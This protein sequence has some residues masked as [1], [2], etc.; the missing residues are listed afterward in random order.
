MGVSLKDVKR[1]FY[2]FRLFF[3]KCFMSNM[4][5]KRRFTREILLEEIDEFCAVTGMTRTKLIC[6]VYGNSSLYSRL[7]NGN[8]CGSEVVDKLRWYMEDHRHDL[9]NRLTNKKEVKNERQEANEI[10]E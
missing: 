4:K 2:A 8:D 1:I 6:E 5:Q 10:Q 7:R 9:L 3:Y